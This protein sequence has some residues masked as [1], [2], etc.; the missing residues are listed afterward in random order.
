MI[1]GRIYSNTLLS[2]A[3]L[4]NKDFTRNL[5]KSLVSI[6]YEGLGELNEGGFITVKMVSRS[7]PGVKLKFP[8]QF[9]RT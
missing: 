1:K 9:E 6:K 4:Q 7:N 3:S 8:S 2:G 5:K